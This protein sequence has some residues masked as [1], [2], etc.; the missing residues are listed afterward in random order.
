MIITCTCKWSIIIIIISLSSSP[1]R[2]CM[3]DVYMV[4]N[5]L[6]MALP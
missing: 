3:H 5:A 4:A 1:M 6:A 2:Y